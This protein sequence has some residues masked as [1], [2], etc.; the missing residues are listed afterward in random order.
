MCNAKTL[1]NIINLLK[2]AVHSAVFDSTKGFLHVPMDEASKLLT[3][4]LTPVEIYQYNVLAMGLSNATGIFESCM[5]QILQGLS[6]VINIADDVLVYGTDYESFKAN[7][8][9]CLDSKL[10][11]QGF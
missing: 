7:V 10:M 6:G 5:C 4:M 2:D 1:D 9:G 11:L 8:T 3:A